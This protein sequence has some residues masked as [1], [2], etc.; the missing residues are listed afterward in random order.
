MF[1]PGAG[2]SAY[3]TALCHA[4]KPPPLAADVPGTPDGSSSLGGTRER[5]V[6]AGVGSAARARPAGGDAPRRPTHSRSCAPVAS[7]HGVVWMNRTAVRAMCRYCQPARGARGRRG[8]GGAARRRGAPLREGQRD[9]ARTRH[10]CHGV[11]QRKLQPDRHNRHCLRRNR[12]SRR[13][14]EQQPERWQ[15]RRTGKWQ[16]RAQQMLRGAARLGR[17]TTRG[18]DTWAPRSAAR[19]GWGWDA[20]ARTLTAR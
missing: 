5:G 20:A 15:H 14:S 10:A 16:S 19:E 18:A 3:A 4:A 13:G 12:R 6:R 8:S 1:A 7:H 2:P 11:R 17:P 9:E